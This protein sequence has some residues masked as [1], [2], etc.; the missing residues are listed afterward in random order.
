MKRA[1]RYDY[2]DFSTVERRR[3]MCQEELRLNRRTAPTLYLDVVPV[4]REPNGELA[5]G[6]H[7]E[8]VEW[9]VGMRRFDQEALLDRLAAR[10]ALDCA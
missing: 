4:T 6:G 10:G 7:G 9:L 5:L 1:V 8:P 3:A 2:L